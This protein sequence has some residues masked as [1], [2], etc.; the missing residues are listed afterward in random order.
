MPK[1]PMLMECPNCC[2][3]WSPGSEEWEIQICSSCGWPYNEDDDENFDEYDYDDPDSIA[4]DN[5]PNDSRNL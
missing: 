3:I 4:E 1:Q 5:N 2:A